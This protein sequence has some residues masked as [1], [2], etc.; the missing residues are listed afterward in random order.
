MNLPFKFGG[1]MAKGLMVLKNVSPE[2]C[3][4]GSILFG[5]GC[6]VTSCMATVKSEPVVKDCIEREETI[7]KVEENESERLRP[8]KE[9]TV[10]EQTAV[11]DIRKDMALVLAKNFAVPV[12][13][14]IAS[15]AL[16]IG[17]VAILRQRLTETS[18]RLA[19]TTVALAGVTK[20]LNE[21]RQRVIED[22][23]VEKDQE[24]LHGLKK[25]TK[26]EVN[27]D[28][29]EVVGEKTEYIQTRAG[30]S[31]YARYFDEGE[32]DDVNKRWIWH[33]F[34]W[35]DD[36]FLNQKTL[37][38]IERE[39]NQK[40]VIDGFLF[41]NDVYR[42]LGMPLSIEGQIVGW[43][44]SGENGDHAVSFRVFDDDP[45]QLP[46]NK[47]FIDGKHNRPLLDFN[48]DGP[49]INDLERFFGKE[50]TAKLVASRI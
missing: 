2:L 8:M 46:Y 35:K 26:V 12:I 17:G 33:N 29:G 7:R 40:L 18:K 10:K 19:E 4:V 45:G 44:Y 25:E 16:N 13:L 50:M 3:A 21:Y 43:S 6:V 5:L 36:N 11:K 28:T 24:Y 39:M 9:L 37:R 14:G 31:Q 15:A 49:I 30:I 32:W 34:T 41:L 23:G 42:R 47:D 27:P 48:V 38:S 1:K 20:T 22:Q